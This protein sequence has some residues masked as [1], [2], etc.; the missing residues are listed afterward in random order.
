[1]YTPEKLL[2]SIVA[3]AA[4]AASGAGGDAGGGGGADETSTAAAVHALQPEEVGRLLG[5]WG[6]SEGLFDLL[7]LQDRRTFKEGNEKIKQLFLPLVEELKR[8]KKALRIG[9]NHGSD[10][11]TNTDICMHACMHQCMHAAIN[12]R[13]MHACVHTCMHRSFMNACMHACMLIIYMHRHA[14]IFR[15]LFVCLRIAVY[16]FVFVLL[17]D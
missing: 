1:M 5:P 3:A 16:L 10:T 14:C 2:S 11:I 17:F 9:V 6:Q 12:T 15:C 4:A 7:S 13:S 8:H